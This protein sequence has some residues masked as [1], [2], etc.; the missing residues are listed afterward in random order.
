MYIV[1]LGCLVERDG[2]REEER[3]KQ[4]DDEKKINI[5]RDLFRA[6]SNYLAISKNKRDGGREEERVKQA[7]DDI[8]GSGSGP[9]T[10]P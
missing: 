8:S 9:Y 5:T 4:A 7:D 2:G 10:L 1:V 6:C 3:V